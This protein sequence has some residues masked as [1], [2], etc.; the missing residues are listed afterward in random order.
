MSLVLCLKFGDNSKVPVDL[1][2]DV[3]AEGEGRDL[4]EYEEAALRG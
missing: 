4:W 3:L 2:T 1:V